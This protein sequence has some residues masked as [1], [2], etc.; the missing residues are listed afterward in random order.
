M[1]SLIVL[2]SHQHLKMAENYSQ[3]QTRLKHD[4]EELQKAICSEGEQLVGMAASPVDRT[5]FEWI[6]IIQG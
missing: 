1:R 6:A 4:F 2:S 3:A 5:M